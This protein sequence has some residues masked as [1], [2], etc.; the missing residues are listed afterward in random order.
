MK[1]P[2]ASYVLIRDKVQR[3]SDA[4]RTSNLTNEV[5]RVYR[6][7]RTGIGAVKNISRKGA[8]AQRKRRKRTCWKFFAAFFAPLRLC[9]FAGNVFSGL[10]D[11][12]ALP[13]SGRQRVAADLNQ[14]PHYRMHD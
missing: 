10:L 5:S 8:K 12:E 6:D 9:A 11:P 13:K 4:S 7:I 14:L 2:A 3:R 1:S